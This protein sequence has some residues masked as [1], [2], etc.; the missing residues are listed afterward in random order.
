MTTYNE[1]AGL[2]VNYLGSDPTLNTGNEGQ[3]WYNSTSGTLKS[4]VQIKAWS[5]GSNM[6]TARYD[7]SGAGTQTAGLA[8]AGSTGTRSNATEEYSGYTWSTGGN[9]PISVSILM[10]GKFSKIQKQ[11]F[12]ELFRKIFP[13]F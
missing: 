9:Y 12:K 13:H 11:L 4:L 10:V 6:S 2:R 3:V 7:L 5:A 1:L 8:F